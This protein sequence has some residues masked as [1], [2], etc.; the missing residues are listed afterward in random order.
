MV[1]V[2]G[3]DCKVPVLIIF[4]NFSQSGAMAVGSG[5]EV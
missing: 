5:S 1:K 4:L 3:N 2:L